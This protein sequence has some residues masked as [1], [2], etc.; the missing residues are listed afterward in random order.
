MPVEEGVERVVSSVGLRFT[1][2]LGAA[3]APAKA[4]AAVKRDVKETIVTA[5]RNLV[6]GDE[7]V[8]E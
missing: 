6:V 8:N 4:V 7:R 2:E 1:I 5:S 3:R